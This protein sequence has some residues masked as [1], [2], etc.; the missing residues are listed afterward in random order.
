MKK[1]LKSSGQK[2]NIKVR[3]IILVLVCL[4][5]LSCVACVSPV[6]EGEDTTGS[7]PKSSL[8]ASSDISFPTTVSGYKTTKSTDQES[9]VESETTAESYPT[10]A[11]TTSRKTQST[12]PSTRQ[13]TTTTSKAT[14]DS[15]TVTFIVDCRNAVL[16]KKEFSGLEDKINYMIERNLCTVDGSMLNQTVTCPVDTTV[17]D[18]LLSLPLNVT[19]STFHP[20]Y[21]MA[22]G[23]LAEKEGGPNSGWVYLVNGIFAMKGSSQYV[24]HD[25]DVV[26]W[27]YTIEKGDVK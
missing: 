12:T 7:L 17:Y 4:L 18:A 19:V 11:S 22:I 6:I 16:R 25:G 27:G 23:G 3:S 5:V 13:S 9:S 24:L 14:S 1:M 2:A 20:G 8:N 21:I 15:I 26:H 10:A